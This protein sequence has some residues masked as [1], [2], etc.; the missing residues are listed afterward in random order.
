[1]LQAPRHRNADL[2]GEAID[3]PGPRATRRPFEVAGR[4]IEGSCRICRIYIYIYMSTYIYIYIFIDSLSYLFTYFFISFGGE[5]RSGHV[6]G[7]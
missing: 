2:A 6:F 1:M 3:H 7:P 4:K 5:S